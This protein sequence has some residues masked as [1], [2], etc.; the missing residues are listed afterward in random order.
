VMTMGTLVYVPG[1]DRQAFVD[2]VR[3]AGVRWIAMERTGTLRDVHRTLP[4]P[5]ALVARG[6]DIDAPEGFATVSLDGVAVA[7]SDAHGTRVH[8]L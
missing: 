3:Q 6:V 1:A 5:V 7:L 2:R 8:W 4:D